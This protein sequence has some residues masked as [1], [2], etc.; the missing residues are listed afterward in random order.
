MASTFHKWR[1][2]QKLESTWRCLWRTCT[3]W[4][5]EG[6][7]AVHA[8]FFAMHTCACTRVQPWACTNNQVIWSGQRQRTNLSA[9]SSSSLWLCL[10]PIAGNGC[11]TWWWP[12]SKGFLCFQTNCFCVPEYLISILHSRKY[13]CVVF[14]RSLNEFINIW[15][16]K[17]T[18]LIIWYFWKHKILI[19]MSK[20]SFSPLRM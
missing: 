4:T 20:T 12:F 2:V 3:L 6:F 19:V 17:L 14:L 15:N 10:A 13:V 5:P 9:V 16:F 18:A 1:P 7:K 11:L 8:D